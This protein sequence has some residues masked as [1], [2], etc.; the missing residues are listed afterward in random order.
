MM[1]NPAMATLRVIKT[2][3][4]QAMASA[5]LSLFCNFY[6]AATNPRGARQFSTIKSMDANGGQSIGYRSEAEGVA[7]PDHKIGR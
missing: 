3:P 1:Q 5:K 2:P 4:E 7:D 6:G